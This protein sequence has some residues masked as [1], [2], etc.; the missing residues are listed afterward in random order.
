MERFW[1]K[2]ERS[3]S[4]WLWLAC[5][6]RDGYGRFRLGD[7]MVQAH[8]LAYELSVGPV[9]NGLQ[10]DHLCRVRACVNPGHLRPL[11][12]TENDRIGMGPPA[13]NARKTRCAHGHELT[14]TNTYRQGGSRRQC[15]LCNGL[16][17]RAYRARL[18][19]PA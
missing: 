3:S 19:V 2:V 17:V 4:C 13:I 10:I 6:S 8:R 5:L 7:R 12:K 1:N 9:P 14:D 16:A 18:R 15:R 11:T